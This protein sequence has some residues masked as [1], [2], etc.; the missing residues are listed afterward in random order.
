L[1]YFELTTGDGGHHFIE[2]DRVRSKKTSKHVYIHIAV[3][4][5]KR[6]KRPP[7]NT[8]NLLR[9]MNVKWTLFLNVKEEVGCLG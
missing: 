9:V 1:F 2:P 5:G 6:M 3:E 7:L 8:I 4:H